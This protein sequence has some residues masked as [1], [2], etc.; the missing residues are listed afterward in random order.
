[1]PFDTAIAM[2]AA[3]AS[4][5]LDTFVLIEADGTLTDLRED[6]EVETLA[7]IVEYLE[8][9]PEMEVDTIHHLI[10]DERRDVTALIGAAVYQAYADA[11]GTHVESAVEGETRATFTERHP[12]YPPLMVAYAFRHLRID[13]MA[14]DALWRG[15][16][17]HWP[18]H[19][20]RVA[21][22]RGAA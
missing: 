8:A 17:Q 16:S 3:P 13:L 5:S 11:H 4:T 18:A 15:G 10:G 21:M 7:D 12:E 14:E 1:M 2:P 6:G 19:R 9:W 20:A 22:V